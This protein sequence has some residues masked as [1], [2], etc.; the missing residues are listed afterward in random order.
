[1]INIKRNGDQNRQLKHDNNQCVGC[2]IC[3]DVCPTHAINLG[4]VLPIARGL[5]EMDNINIDSDKCALCGI[6]ASSCPFGA[7]DF[8]IGGESTSKIKEYPYWSHDTIINEEN[9]IYCQACQN[10]CPQDAITV[11]RELP[12][13]KKLVSGEIEIDENECIHCGICSELCPA[14]AITLQTGD[15]R[16]ESIEVN[17]DKCVYCLVC[18]RACPVDAIKTVCRLC[19]YG[20]VDLNP[21]DYQTTGT[22]V[23]N[24]NNCVSCGWC[25]EVCPVDA[26]NVSK[27]FEGEIVKEE[28]EDCKGE[29]CHACQDVCPCNAIKLVDGKI[30]INPKVCVLCGACTQTCPQNTI[31]ITRKNMKLENLKSR[32][33]KKQLGKILN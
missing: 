20:D 15:H 14:E 33:W 10:I 3:R 27:P 25:Q 32:S 22:T 19:S 7:L 26:I 16:K 2:G 13:R 24:F 1:M 6:C 18:K 30:E 4:P 31:H 12:E 11:S 21:E 9:C 23:L 29:T 8:K 17:L 5:I 28:S